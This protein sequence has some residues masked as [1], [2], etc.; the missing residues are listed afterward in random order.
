M[1]LPNVLLTQSNNLFEVN[2]D[3]VHF[4][5]HTNYNFRLLHNSPAVDNGFDLSGFGVINDLDYN[6]RPQENGYDIGA[7]EYISDSISMQNATLMELTEKQVPNIE[8]LN[9][10]ATLKKNDK[11]NLKSE[12]EI[13][14]STDFEIYPNPSYGQFKLIRKYFSNVN[15]SI[16]D[17]MGNIVYRENNIK[18]LDKEIDISRKLDE[19]K[20]FITLTDANSKTTKSILINEK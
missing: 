10:T 15:I 14:P 1:N 16:Y 9:S 20:Y 13:I 2:I 3:S 17:V 8:N 5:D 6:L 4:V 7:Y 18:D 11:I 19:V 12:N